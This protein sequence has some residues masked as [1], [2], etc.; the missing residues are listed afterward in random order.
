MKFNLKSNKTIH[1]LAISFSFLLLFILQINGYSQ[2]TSINCDGT[3]T[4]GLY[5]S[6]IGG[7]TS[8]TGNYSFAGGLFSESSGQSSF[9]FG[10]RAK[11]L[12]GSSIALGQFIKVT[13]STAIG[14]GIGFDL[15]NPLVNNVPMSFMIGMGSSKPT[16]FVSES[17]GVN[18]T[19]RI[20]IGNITDPQAKLHIRADK[21]E[22]ASLLL[23]PSDPKNNSAQLRFMDDNTGLTA[24]IKGGLQLFTNL[25]IMQ[26]AAPQFVFDGPVK[27]ALLEVN[28]AYNLPTTAGTSDQFLRA[29]GTWAVPDAGV[30]NYWQ[31]SGNNI[32]FDNAVGIGMEPKERL[33]IDSPYGRPIHF[34][35]GGS[36]GINNNAWYNGTNNVRSE[37][38]PAYQISFS[39]LN[40][41]FKAAENENAGSIVNWNEAL[42]ITQQG[43][44]GIGTNDTKTY[45]LAVK[46]KMIAEEIVV[47]YANEWPDYV[48]EPTYP[49]MSLVELQQFVQTHHHLPDM[50]AAEQVAEAG[51]PVGE[52]NALLLK[53]VEEL[54]LYVLQQQQAMEKQQ[55][56]IDLLKQKLQE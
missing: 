36:Q 46:G 10:N 18:L 2:C 51:M 35:I 52:M 55:K 30:E 42:V 48:F 14:I 22:D 32:F 12:G 39:N 25:E 40:M 37:D 7:Y 33:S 43:N 34:H 31:P 53:K 50:P 6:A 49:L 47:K 45:K 27:V 17:I 11:A 1:Y 29:D 19:G 44:V 5:P 8:A 4:S 38:G 16:F 15:D 3:T 13:A 23:E 54:T 21:L 56:E 26:F 28:G 20:G 41:A 9:S 24:S